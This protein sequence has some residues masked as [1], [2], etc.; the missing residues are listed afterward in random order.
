MHS[1]IL[2]R[3]PEGADSRLVRASLETAIPD[4]LVLD[5]HEPD[6]QVTR[7]LDAWLAFLR[8]TAWFALV[9]ASVAAAAA[10]H[11]MMS[12]RLDTIA[13]IKAL[14]GRTR[15]V[16]QGYLI[17]VFAMSMIAMPLACGVGAAIQAI[18]LRL[19]GGVVACQARLL[20]GLADRR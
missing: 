11:W 17:P 16:L 4:A 18:T 12:D 1:R 9:T 15:V 8:L 20:L 2:L 19:L 6:P 10:A 5:W 7:I 13:V 3:L 14:G